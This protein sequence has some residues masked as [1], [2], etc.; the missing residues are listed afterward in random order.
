MRPLALL[1]VLLGGLA[2]A[3]SGQHAQGSARASTR[4]HTN[5]LLQSQNQATTPWGAFDTVITENAA[6]APNGTSTAA[7]LHINGV[8]FAGTNY[9]SLTL[10]GKN[11]GSVWLRSSSGTPTVYVAVSDGA[12]TYY[13]T[14]AALTTSWRRFSVVTPALASGTWFFSVGYDTRDATQV[15]PGALD[16]YEWGSQVSAG[17]AP[18][19]YIHTTSAAAS[20]RC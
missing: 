4:L 9:Q 14:A 3:Q 19:C 16:I 13:K 17:G 12:G 2:F 7:Q 18:A 15:N 10:A 1:T 5:V 6:V 11:T 20:R 8:Q